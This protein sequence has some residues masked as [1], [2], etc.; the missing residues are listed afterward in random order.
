MS[1]YT[2]ILCN[3]RKV[4]RFIDG[5]VGEEGFHVKTRHC[6]I[7]II[8]DGTNFIYECEAVLKSEFIGSGPNSSPMIKIIQWRVLTWNPSSPTF[9]SMKRS[10]LLV[11]PFLILTDSLTLFS[12]KTL[13]KWCKHHRIQ[14]LIHTISFS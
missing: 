8:G 2:I 14:M 10:T 9:P 7:L 13:G 5:N 12:L 3:F 11:I 1:L 6:I 4:D